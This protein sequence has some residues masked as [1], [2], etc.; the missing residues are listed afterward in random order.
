M[1]S[2]YPIQFDSFSPLLDV[3][4]VNVVYQEAENSF[5]I[6]SAGY[7]LTLILAQEQEHILSLKHNV[8]IFNMGRGQ[9]P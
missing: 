8:F 2:F 5:I 9:I 1:V 6:H 4:T 3:C 7:V